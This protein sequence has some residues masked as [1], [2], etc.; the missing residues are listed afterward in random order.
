MTMDPNHERRA[1][2]SLLDTVEELCL[3]LA[4]GQTPETEWTEIVH[5]TFD[6]HRRELAGEIVA[7]PQEH[8]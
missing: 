1:L 3:G 8:E 6:K 4:H 7:W 5:D 2:L